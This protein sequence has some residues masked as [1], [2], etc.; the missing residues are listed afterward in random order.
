MVWIGILIALFQTI[1]L[2][3]ANYYFPDGY[4]RKGA[5]KNE[6]DDGGS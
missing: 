3:I 4:H 6:D 5:V 1:A 2:K